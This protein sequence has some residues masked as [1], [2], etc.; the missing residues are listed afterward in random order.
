M[1]VALAAFLA[2]QSAQPRLRGSL[3]AARVGGGALGVLTKGLVAAAIPAAVLVLYSLCV[4]RFLA[5]ATAA[6]R[7]RHCRCLW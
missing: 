2:A 6:C 1:T 7:G 4:A 3:D 5:L